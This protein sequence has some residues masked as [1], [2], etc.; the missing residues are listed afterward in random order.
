[1]VG[2]INIRP[3][4]LCGGFGK[5]LK[6]IS[7]IKKP[8]QFLKVL[9]DQSMFQSVMERVSNKSIFL[10][11][12]VI[13]NT[14]FLKNIKDDL[15]KTNLTAQIILEPFSRNTST[16]II[17]SALL[18][19]DNEYLL[20]LPSDHIIQNKSAFETT[21]EETINELK[22]S[23][24]EE[25]IILFGVKNDNFSENFGYFLCEGQGALNRITSFI[26]KP[27]YDTFEEKLQHKNYF[28]NSGM[29]LFKKE[30]FLKQVQEIL[31]NIYFNSCEAVKSLVKERGYKIVGNQI[32]NSPNIS[33]DYALMEK[34]Y[35]LYATQLKSDWLDVG[36]LASFIEKISAKDLAKIIIYEM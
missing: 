21:I 12:L 32:K 15:K 36:N 6:P 7:S 8:K 26:E 34:N 29:F 24:L 14:I 27:S 31:P 23:N 22:N 16:S 20:I 17:I 35:N 3:V 9:E 2:K 25:K 11:P 5:R 4:I 13:S 19:N 18:A 10:E 1:M 30:F 28:I 33:I